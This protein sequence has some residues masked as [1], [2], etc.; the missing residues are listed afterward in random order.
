MLITPYQGGDSLTGGAWC[1][2][3]AHARRAEGKDLSLSLRSDRISNVSKDSETGLFLHRLIHN[4]RHHIIW[5]ALLGELDGN[6]N[7]QHMLSQS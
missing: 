2:S 7:A 4:G 5:Y 6:T 1:I 3:I